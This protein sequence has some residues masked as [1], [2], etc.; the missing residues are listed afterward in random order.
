MTDP[1]R[2]HARSLPLWLV[3]A[4][5]L[6]LMT[7]FGLG[8]RTARH[9]QV[10]D[11]DFDTA[12]RRSAVAGRTIRVL[13]DE[14]H[15]NFHTAGGRYRPFA[16]LLRADGFT[17]ERGHSPFTPAALAGVDVLVVANAEPPDEEA[18]SS[19]FT[20]AEVAAV[21]QWV[22][23]GGGLL[24]IADHAPFGAAAR[25]LA[26]AFGVILHD[27]HLRDP[28]HADDDLAS[29]YVLVFERSD[30]LVADHAITRGRGPDEV[31]RRVV[32]FGGE[33]LEGPPGSTPLLRL[34][35]T[36]EIVDDPERGEDAAVRSAA[37]MAQ[38]VALT[39][40]RGRVVV[41]GEA[42]VFTSQVIT[43]EVAEKMGREELRIGMSRTDTDDR[44]LALNTARW[45]AGLL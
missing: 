31:V 24:L 35:D 39:H 21:E 38:A 5:A 36:A 30:G 10:A 6:S 16:D 41:L 42:A 17:V 29:P 27:Q 33:A 23:D 26:A 3:L 43:G 45:L 22:R 40:G 28:E 15:E 37:G 20:A 18:P 13:V 7:P 11:P 14:A 25:D 2:R 4:L 32:T 8:C 44:Q 1:R 34:A 9:H 12:V 19:A